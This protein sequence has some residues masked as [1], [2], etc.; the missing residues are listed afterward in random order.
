MTKKTRTILFFI[1]VFL[2]ALTAPTVIL[3]SQGYRFDLATKKVVQTGGLYLKIS[4]RNVQVYINGKLKST[5]SIFSNSSLVKN[6]LPKT[7]AVEI[8][9]DGYYSWQ[10]T[11]EVKEKQATEAKNIV[12]IPE[13]P[14]FTKLDVTPTEFNAMVALLVPNATSSDGQKVIEV[15]NHE[16]WISFPKEEKRIFLNRF[17]E[18]ISKVFWFNDYYLIFNVA[19]KIKVAEIDDRDKLNIINLAEF[20]NPEIFWDSNNGKLY[21]STRGKFYVSENLLP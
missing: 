12:L 10:K 13:N 20:E 14:G 2:F 18:S 1:C 8:R 21:V 5:T 19:N 4:P 6:L 9:K 7:Y 17:S 15:D 16:V 3:Y 11:L